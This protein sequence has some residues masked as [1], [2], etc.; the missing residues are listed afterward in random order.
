[1]TAEERAAFYWLEHLSPAQRLEQFRPAAVPLLGFDEENRLGAF[2]TLKDDHEGDRAH[3]AACK[4][5]NAV[6][7]A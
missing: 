3:C 4:D 2:A 7:V 5:P 6:V 1:M